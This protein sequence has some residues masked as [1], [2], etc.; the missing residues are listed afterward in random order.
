MSKSKDEA[1]MY[2]LV[3]G[4]SAATPN[5][6]GWVCTSPC[7]EENRLGSWSAGVKP[8]AGAGAAMSWYHVWADVDWSFLGDAE[9]EKQRSVSE[10]AALVTPLIV[11][12]CYFTIDCLN[13]H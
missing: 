12:G 2:G 8:G 6:A 13:N 11:L 1:G 3:A 9:S 7:D 10:Y 5:P 4:S